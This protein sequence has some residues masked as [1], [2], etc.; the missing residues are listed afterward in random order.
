MTGKHHDRAAVALHAVHAVDAIEYRKSPDSHPAR[1][2]RLQPRA[3]ALR[4]SLVAS[5]LQLGHEGVGRATA[6]KPARGLRRPVSN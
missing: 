2:D 1:V 3:A 6:T 4:C 5:T